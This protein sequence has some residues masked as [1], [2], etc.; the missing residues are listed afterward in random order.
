MTDDL[1]LQLGGAGL[2]TL[3]QQ[4]SPAAQQVVMAAFGVG[5][6]VGVMLPFS[7]SQE[8][9]ADHIGLVLMAKAGY[10][11]HGAL[12]VRGAPPDATVLRA[13]VDAALEAGFVSNNAELIEERGVLRV[14]GDPTEGALKVAAPFKVERSD[15][16]FSSSIRAELERD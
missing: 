8:S 15:E 2:Q 6:T 4:K 7:R 14:A 11:P 9:E 13:E 3:L 16:M 5:A 10:D 1:A 12:R